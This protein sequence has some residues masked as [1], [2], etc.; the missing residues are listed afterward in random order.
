MVQHVLQNNTR[1]VQTKLSVGPTNDRYEQEADRVA[2]RVMCMPPAEAPIQ[3][4]CAKC[5]EEEE[6]ELQMQAIESQQSPLQMTPF[7][8]L[9]PNHSTNPGR[10]W[11]R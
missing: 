6:E 3:R 7:S 8:E 9:P 10:R 2:D 1:K 11:S 5:E 4:K